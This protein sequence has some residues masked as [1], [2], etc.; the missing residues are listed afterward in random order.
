[1][2]YSRRWDD[3]ARQC[4]DMYAQ[5]PL[6][7]R[8]CVRWRHQTGLLVLKVT[9][10]AKCIKFK[11]HS[12]AFLNRFEQLNRDLTAAMQNKRQRSRQHTDIA[13]EAIAAKGD[14]AGTD[15][16]STHEQLLS[17][18][19]SSQALASTTTSSGKKKKNKKKK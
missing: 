12:S 16:T 5:E 7:T 15:P 19:P 18:T 3:F 1:M 2:V 10:D 8:Y 17:A 9:D 14:Q 11:T 6:K 4:K 13:D